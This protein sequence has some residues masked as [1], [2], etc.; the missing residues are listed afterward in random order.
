MIDTSIQKS[1]YK[2]TKQLSWVFFIVKS[3]IGLNSLYYA[4]GH[5][6]SLILGEVLPTEGQLQETTR[7]ISSH[8]KLLP[9]KG[10]PFL[11]HKIP[12]TK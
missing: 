5:D 10:H 9:L 8:P 7:L 11:G 3:I 4:H 12:N 6:S 1:L 2:D